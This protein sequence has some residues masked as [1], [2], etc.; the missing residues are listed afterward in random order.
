MTWELLEG[1]Y[2]LHDHTTNAE[3]RGE[4]NTYNF[5]KSIVI[6]DASAHNIY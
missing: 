5:K 3:I 6:T 4:T 1:V 2:T